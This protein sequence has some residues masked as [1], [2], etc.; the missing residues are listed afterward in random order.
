VNIFI[1]GLILDTCSTSRIEQRRARA[2]CPIGDVEL[3]TVGISRVPSQSRRKM[4][5]EEAVELATHAVQADIAG[6]VATAIEFYTRAADAL[7]RA[8]SVTPAEASEMRGKSS[9]YRARAGVLQQKLEVSH[10]EAMAQSAQM[11]QRGVQIAGRTDAAVKTAGGYS[12]V[13]G[14]AAVGAVAGAV[15]LGPITA[16]VAAGGAAYAT[17]RKDSVGDVARQTGR[18]AAAAA[19]AAK[20]FNNEH[21]ITGKL[22]VATAAAANKA[23]EVNAKYGITSKITAGASSAYNQA[24]EFD[25]NHNVTGKVGSSISSGLS[26]FTSAVGGAPAKNDGLP[27][28]PK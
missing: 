10:M 26:A 19:T 16:I 15:A 25:K 23:K 21:D 6:E 5:C 20:K 24:A 3:V 4:P 8:A 12:A 1:A 28:V 22:Y 27:A 9:E 13:A 7:D 2:W 18:A 14:A 11:A 17:T